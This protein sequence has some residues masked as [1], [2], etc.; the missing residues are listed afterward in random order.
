M[1]RFRPENYFEPSGTTEA[2]LLALELWASSTINVMEQKRGCW[3]WRWLKRWR[4]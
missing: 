2:R 4:V 1:S 3:L